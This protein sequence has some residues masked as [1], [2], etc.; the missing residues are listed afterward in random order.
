MQRRC[1]KAFGSNITPRTILSAFTRSGVCVPSRRDPYSNRRRIPR[2][3]FSLRIGAFFTLS[4]TNRR[5]TSLPHQLGVGRP[6]RREDLKECDAQ[7]YDSMRSRANFLTSEAEE[8]SEKADPRTTRLNNSSREDADNP[9]HRRP[10][11]TG[12]PPVKQIA[13]QE[14]GNQRRRDDLPGSDRE[15]DRDKR[16]HDGIARVSIPYRRQRDI[17]FSSTITMK[18][19]DSR[20]MS[21]ATA[22]AGGLMLAARTVAAQQQVGHDGGMMG[23]AHGAWMAG[24]GGLWALLPILAIVGL[25]AWIVARGRSKL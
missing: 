14:Q 1:G 16:E 13:A 19:F 17:I 7:C 6:R 15:D 10:R 4:N 2:R 5:S 3:R 24:H 9:I 18:F 21:G 23:G 22:A 25:L 8:S 20:R 12:D 11:T